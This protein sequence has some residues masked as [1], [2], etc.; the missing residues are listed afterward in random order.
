MTAVPDVVMLPGWLS[1]LMNKYSE[2][3]KTNAAGLV[4]KH[5]LRVVPDMNPA[6][7]SA[8]EAVS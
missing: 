1:C 8:R 3:T 4:V 7:F 5:P 2:I 6:T